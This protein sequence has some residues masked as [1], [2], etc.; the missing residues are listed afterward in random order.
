MQLDISL[1]K[2]R[3]KG[4][5]MH[6]LVIHPVKRRGE[7]GEEGEGGEGGTER[8]QMASCTMSDTHI[9][10]EDVNISQLKIHGSKCPGLAFYK[11]TN[12]CEDMCSREVGDLV[13]RYIVD[14]H[15]NILFLSREQGEFGVSQGDKLLVLRKRQQHV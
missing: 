3:V 7:G 15:F 11:P 10:G 5:E 12:S 13:L 1:H 8:M 2:T 9:N 6:I 14:I 4:T